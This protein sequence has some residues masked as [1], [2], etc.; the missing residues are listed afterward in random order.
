[1]RNEKK[2]DRVRNGHAIGLLPITTLNHIEANDQENYV[3]LKGIAQVEQY[4][5]KMKN[6]QLQGFNC[7]AGGGGPIATEFLE[8]RPL[9]MKLFDHF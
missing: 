1:M 8:T 7:N 5:I 9:S 6:A 3:V 2:I 4:I